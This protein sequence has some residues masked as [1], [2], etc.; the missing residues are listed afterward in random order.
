MDLLWRG[1]R[2][3]TSS[4]FSRMGGDGCHSGNGCYTCG[5]LIHGMTQLLWSGILA[6]LI[7]GGC[8]AFYFWRHYRSG[9]GESRYSWGAV[10][11]SHWLIGDA[12]TT[13]ILELG[14]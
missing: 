13:R 8:M 5:V 4:Q 7:V 12:F 3:E 9:I 1:S 2:S 11:T 6:G 14:K 10:S